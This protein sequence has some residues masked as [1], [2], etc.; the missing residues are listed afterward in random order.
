MVANPTS[1]QASAR[2]G[3][4]GEDTGRLPHSYYAATAG[5]PVVAPALDGDATADFCIIGGGFA[6][7]GAALALAR[8]G[9]S[10]RLI[11]MGPIGWVAATAAAR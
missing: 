11:E 1:R 5:T 8:L 9:H 2:A 3:P 6:G 4:S 7:L 10:V